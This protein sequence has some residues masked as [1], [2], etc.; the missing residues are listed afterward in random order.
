MKN[1]KRL[2]VPEGLKE[3]IHEKVYSYHKKSE[4][5]YYKYL[6]VIHLLYTHATL[7]KDDYAKS[8]VALFSGILNETIGRR[9]K[10]KMF[11]NLRS[12]GYI[13]LTKDYCAG[14]HS[15]HYKLSKMLECRKFCIVTVPASSASF[16]KK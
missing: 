10:A 5:L 6:Y 1:C 4:E 14:E 15:R 12:W 16:I 2:F 9:D 3:N 11:L 7:Y 13:W 8:G